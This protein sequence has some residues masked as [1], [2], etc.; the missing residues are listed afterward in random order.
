MAGPTEKPGSIPMNWRAM[1]CAG[2]EKVGFPQTVGSIGH[3][4]WEVNGLWLH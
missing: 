2:V 3:D 4:V 1:A